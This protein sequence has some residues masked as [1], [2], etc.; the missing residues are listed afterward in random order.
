MLPFVIHGPLSRVGP[1]TVES[2]V[3]SWNFLRKLNMEH[4]NKSDSGLE[5]RAKTFMEK[6][7]EYAHEIKEKLALKESKEFRLKLEQL[8]DFI[9]VSCDRSAIRNDLQTLRISAD[10]PIG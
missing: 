9:A 10:N 1:D 3:I 4:Q 7:H 8:E 2:L 6:G 5:T